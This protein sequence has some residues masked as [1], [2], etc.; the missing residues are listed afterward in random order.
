MRLQSLARLIVGLSLLFASG[1]A[2][3][4]QP[5]PTPVAPADGGEAQ[6]FNA[7]LLP[8]PPPAAPQESPRR[9]AA[10]AVQAQFGQV[11]RL[12]AGDGE[13]L[14]YFGFAVALDG[15]VAVV[16]AYRD[17]AA[18]PADPNCDSG[19]V[20]I[21]ARDQG[22][23]DHWGQVIKLTAGDMGQSAQ[24]GWS[25]A[26]DGDRLA[27][28]SPGD[29][30]GGYYAGAA[31]L[32]E[33]NAGGADNWG[34]VI[35]LTAADRAE[36]DLFGFSVAIDGD[37]VLAGARYDDDA[38]PADP[39]CNSG[40]AYLFSRDGGNW[41][42]VI[43]LT[44]GDA[45]Q[46]DWFGYAASLDGETAAVSA[47]R[48]DDACAADPDC[49]SGSAYLFQRDQGGGGAWGQA[50][51][52]VA[53]DDARGDLFGHSLS[54]AGGFLLVGAPQDDDACP[55]DPACDSG[56]AYLFWR[57]P[58]GAGAWQQVTKLT[59][60]DAAQGD[61]FG[62][63]VA[64]DGDLAAVGAVQ[65]DDAAADAGAA[66][67]FHRYRGGANHWGQVAKMTAADGAAQDYFGYSVGLSGGTL[68][69]GAPY[70]DNRG[71]NSGS[72]YVLR[73]VGILID[74]LD[75]EDWGAIQPALVDHPGAPDPDAPTSDYQD[76]EY[77]Y[78]AYGDDDVYLRIDAAAGPPEQSLIDL[79]VDNG[80]LDCPEEVGHG[81]GSRYD[82]HIRAEW[83]ADSGEW[84][85]SAARCEAGNAW[86]AAQPAGYARSVGIVELAVPRAHFGGAGGVELFVRYG[87]GTDYAPDANA[88]PA[89]LVELASFAAAVRDGAVR[90]AW[91]T[92]S[93]I[94]TAG[95]HLYRADGEEGEYVRLTAQV[96][97]ARGGPAQSASYQFD[98]AGVVA[99]ATYYYRL[100]DVDVEGVGTF[101]GPA[102]VWV[103]EQPTGVTLAGFRAGG[104]APWPAVFVLVAL[105]AGLVWRRPGRRAP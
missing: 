42:Q 91:E 67:T 25:V 97:P 17:D 36:G 2:A 10:A 88:G 35:K 59:A 62:F 75:T 45:A 43:K 58:A 103:G 85:A 98:D 64:L 96:I 77:V 18:C 6:P 1:P 21:F 105:V 7:P 30:E 68:L 5:V 79:Y 49:S 61:L 48:D 76:I 65:E 66:Y 16:G 14:D 39:N 80:P 8:A 101:H 73:W 26:L 60:G 44:A 82:L 38:C 23:P 47:I 3:A 46:G 19:A 87:T 29:D 55:A 33:R 86:G 81:S 99:G 84:Q 32:F 50:G 56:S 34:Q 89:S 27:V 104:H 94:D 20:Y 37:L 70:D 52:V 40:S 74:G 69:A 72:A 92:A 57:N 100:E 83:S 24:F 63:G 4:A 15:D 41:S 90:V 11:A 71:S 13:A 53:A 93:E 9:D 12:E 22:G 95:F 102:A 54:L 31:Y 78:A 51:K 28:G